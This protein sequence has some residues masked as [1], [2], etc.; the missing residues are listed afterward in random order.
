MRRLTLETVP[1][2]VA[3][4]K[5]ENDINA[6]VTMATRKSLVCPDAFKNFDGTGDAKLIKEV[7]G[8]IPSW[9]AADYSDLLKW[10]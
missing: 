4:Y 10:L 6:I 1:V 7:F 3:D 8:L 2:I 9:C 5:L